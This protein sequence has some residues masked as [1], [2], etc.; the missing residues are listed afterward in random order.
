[1]NIYEKLQKARYE[2]GKLELKKTGKNTF[3]KYDYFELKDFL[4]EINKLMYE[5]KFTS[6]VDF[7]EKEATLYII[8]SEKPEEFI[9]FTSPMAQV[10][11]KGAHAIQN[12][13]AVETYQRRYLYMT[14]FEISEN[15]IID[16]GNEKNAEKQE[17]E[18]PKITEIQLMVLREKMKKKGIEANRWH[19]TMLEELNVEEFKSAMDALEARPDKPEQSNLDL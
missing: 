8:D 11:L 18:P 10:E 1:M 9:P 3:S 13:G 14:A 17:E 7:G 4:P 6:R 16:S 12:I 5:N 15:D 2:L 19:G